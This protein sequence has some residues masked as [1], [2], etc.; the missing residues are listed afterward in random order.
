MTISIRE[1]GPSDAALIHAVLCEAAAWLEGRDEPVWSPDEVSLE[2]IS[3]EVREGFSYCLAESDGH[4]VGTLRFQLSDEEA[5]PDLPEGESAFVHRLAIRRSHAGG[6]LSADLIQWAVDR[7]TAI[8]RRYLRLDCV[9]SR[10]KLRTLYERLG[11]RFHS[12]RQIEFGQVARYELSLGPPGREGASGTL[13]S[14]PS[15]ST[16]PRTSR[17]T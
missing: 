6:E 12:L 8:G 17:D 7:A 4:P 5:W 1:A 16:S 10:S 9:A 13:A 2:T 11:F 15:A 3:R 14:Q